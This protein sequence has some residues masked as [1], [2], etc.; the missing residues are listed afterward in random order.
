MPHE[1]TR[2]PGRP[3]G[4]HRDQVRQQLLDAAHALFLSYEFK[5]VSV[6]R[7]ADR[8]GVNPAMVNYYFGSKQ[9]LYLA[10]VEQMIESVKPALDALQGRQPPSL[11]SFIS[12]FTQFLAANPWWPN[13]VIREVLYG[14]PDF[15]NRILARMNQT[16]IRGALEVMQSAIS[17]NHFRADLDPQLAAMSLMGMMFYPFLARPVVEQVLQVRLDPDHVG[18][19]ASHTTALFHQGALGHVS[20]EAPGRTRKGDR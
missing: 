14:R 12:A 15:R 5:A 9:G 3:P 6:R 13:F 11:E 7:I 10:M 1:L 2:S 19:L 4:S 18:Q 16:L 20:R 17:R 8:A